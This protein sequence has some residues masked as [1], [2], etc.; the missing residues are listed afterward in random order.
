MNRICLYVNRQQVKRDG[1]CAIYISTVVNGQPVRFHTGVSAPVDAI[2]FSREVIRGTAKEVKDK[3]LIISNCKARISDIFVR[4]RLRFSELTPELL[5]S[6]YENY[7]S[8]FLYYDYAMKKLNERKPDL[9]Q[10][11]YK[12][13]KSVLGKIKEFAP[14]LRLGDINEQFVQDL[15]R[16]CRNTCKN[17][18]STTHNAIKT[19]KF[20][21]HRALREGL[22]KG[23]PFEAVR[24][25]DNI[26]TR[27]YLSP[28]ELQIFISL[29]KKNTLTPPLQNVLRY[30][31][32]SCL[33]GLRYSDV[34]NFSHSNIVGST[35]VVQMQK[36]RKQGYK[37]RCPKATISVT[38][39]CATSCATRLNVMDSPVIA[40]TPAVITPANW[41]NLPANWLKAEP[42]RFEFTST[43]LIR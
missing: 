32:F 21:Y 36:T 27:E 13:H 25:R 37:E 3:N 18:L 2:D 41:L 1:A 38:S 16:W 29:Y 39:M 40:A 20:Y 15:V 12:R 42:H 10:S 17:E 4:Y 14:N 6:E 24:V 26:A 28:E 31:L 7:L 35:I 33:T 5:R 34:L 8:N 22:V 9:A 11:S 23:N 30:F 19:F 43:S